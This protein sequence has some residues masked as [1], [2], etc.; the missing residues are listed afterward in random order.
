MCSSRGTPV[1]LSGKV[2]VPLKVG[3]NTHRGKSGVP[4]E[5]SMCSS[6]GKPE[7]KV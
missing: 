7:S 1:Y 5:V 4:L 3:L 6:R 2:C